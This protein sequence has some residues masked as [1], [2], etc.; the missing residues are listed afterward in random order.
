[1]SNQVTEKLCDEPICILAS[2]MGSNFE[3]LVSRFPLQ[4]FFLICNVPHAGCLSVAEKF[5][6]SSTTISSEGKSRSSFEKEL[7]EVISSQGNVKWIVLAGFMRILS[8]TFFEEQKRQLPAARII[9]LHPA[10]R[11]DYKGAHAYE[12]AVK[13]KF[14]RWGL[15]VHETTPELDSGPLLGSEEH[16]V[17]PWETQHVLHSRLRTYEHLLLS[18]TLQDLCQKGASS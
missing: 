14:P 8:S 3:A 5:K 16:A 1:M 18:K 4:K 13:K 2:G 15:S 10:H 6:V 9:N 17:Y 7:V 11:E 12:F